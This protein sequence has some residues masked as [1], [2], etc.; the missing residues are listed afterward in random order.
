MQ[1]QVIE[2]NRPGQQIDPEPPAQPDQPGQPAPPP[3]P[4][5]PPADPTP[6]SDQSAP[7]A[8]GWQFKAEDQPAAAPGGAVPSSNV[9]PVSWTASEYIDHQKGAGWY[10]LLLVGGALIAGVLYLLTRDIVSSVIVLIA[11]I[12]L[13][14]FAARK[15]RTLQYQVDDTGVTIGPKL[16][17]YGL[18]KAFWVSDDTAVGS[19]T[20]L[21]LKRFMPP[22]TLYYDNKDEDSI[23]EVIGSF[24]PLEQDH[25]DHVDRLMHRIRF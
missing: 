10:L 24:L 22:I 11:V 23:V 4:V 2:P 6:P 15:P 25:K 18:F 14:V 5:P 1:P 3:Q 19:I 17:Q 16:Y 7:P 13:A 8:A 20:L 21:P 9:Q 12:I